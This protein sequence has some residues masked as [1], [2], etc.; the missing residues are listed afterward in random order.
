M[1]IN[2]D[3]QMRKLP[4][5]MAQRIAMRL[6]GGTASGPAGARRQGLV[7]PR[8]RAPVRPRERAAVEAASGKVDRPIFSRC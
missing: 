8:L 4:A 1:R 5:M 7:L 6:K 2:N 3:S